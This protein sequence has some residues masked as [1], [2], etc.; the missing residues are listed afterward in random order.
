[1]QIQLAVAMYIIWVTPVRVVSMKA[2]AN[3]SASQPCNDFER[4]KITPL[5]SQQQLYLAAAVE[6]WAVQLRPANN[7]I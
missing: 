1:M 7:D 4:G 2:A 6:L 5:R 3:G